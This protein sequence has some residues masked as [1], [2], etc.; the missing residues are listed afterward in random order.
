MYN[1]VQYVNN[2]RD[3][4]SSRKLI[5]YNIITLVLILIAIEGVSLLIFKLHSTLNKPDKP[6]NEEI[7]YEAYLKEQRSAQYISDIAI[8]DDHTRFK[9]DNYLFKSFLMYHNKPFQSRFVNVNERGIRENGNAIEK[10]AS[11]DYHIWAFG[12]SALFGDPANADYETMPAYLEAILNKTYPDI[13]FIVTNYGANSYTSIQEYLLF[14][15]ELTRHAPDMVITFDGYNDY[16]HIFADKIFKAYIGHNELKGYWNLHQ[17]E[18]IINSPM[19]I[20]RFSSLMPNTKRLIKKGRKLI[21]L[22]NARRDIE[23]WKSDYIAKAEAASH[24]Q[25]LRMDLGLRAYLENIEMIIL[26]C[27]ERNLPDFFLHQPP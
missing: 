20:K 16:C 12:S 15:L 11:R 9:E 13:N 4:M 25:S 19:L 8:F 22:V 6:N 26:A 7:S 14:K 5:I 17:R 2:E 1:T 18:G 21:R 24:R 10:E 23:G 3:G 27:K